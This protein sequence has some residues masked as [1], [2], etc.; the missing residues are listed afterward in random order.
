MISEPA[1]KKGP[2]GPFLDLVQGS[3]SP[4]TPLAFGSTSLRQNMVTSMSEQK[5]TQATESSA[6]PKRE[7]V[8]KVRLDDDEYR[9]VKEISKANKKP[10]AAL[11]RELILHSGASM[12][13]VDP[14]LIRAI[15]Y[16]GNNLN[17]IARRINSSGLPP[18]T[19]LDLQSQLMR[20]SILLKAILENQK[21]AR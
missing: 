13:R 6:N 2:F 5:E 1:Y 12:R 14:E 10:I 4:E 7:K 9:K 20:N 15:N 3:A 8:L 19:V 11:M 18:D 21:N 16:I 17:Q